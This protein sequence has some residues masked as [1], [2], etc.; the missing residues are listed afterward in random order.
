[1]PHVDANG[2]R[3]YYEI[4]G[5]GEPLLLVM[6]LAADMLAWTL[7][8]PAWS[9]RYRV[10]AF[11]NRD[12]GQSSYAE[13]PYSVSDM[14]ADTL[15][16][17]DTLELDSFHLLGYSMGGAVAQEVALAAA[18]RVRTLSLCAS[19]AGSGRY[20]LDR[21]RLWSAQVERMSHEEHID[22]LLQL[23]MTEAFY[24]NEEG[25]AFVRRM[26]LQ[27][28]HPQA[29]EA[30]IRQ[31]RASSAHESRDRIGALSMPVH[32]IGCEYDI[33]LPVWKSKELA[34]LIPGARYTMLEGAAHGA[35]IEHAAVFNAAVLEFLQ[36][37]AQPAA[38]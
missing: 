38:A 20:A 14:A 3:L 27:N 19:W 37:S 21:A 32:V 22:N 28:P 4:H 23:T 34:E 26:M 7:Q 2:Q 5:E 24:E 6:G 16:L 18:Q 36:A 10:I 29:P 30:F 35:N 9:E 15:A 33:L 11:D 31:L 17:A 1:M 13:G 25:L 12:V 8:V